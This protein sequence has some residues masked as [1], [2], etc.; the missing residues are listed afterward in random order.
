[1]AFVNAADVYFGSYAKFTTLGK[2]EGAAKAGPDN[3]I[4][5]IGTIEFQLDD[6][7]RSIAWMKNRFGHMVGQLDPAMSYTLAVMNAKGW[8]L[9][10]VLSFVAFTEHPDS[11]KNSYWGEVA[12][13]AFAPRYGEEFGEFMRTFSLQVADGSRPNPALTNIEVEGILRDPISWKPVMTIDMPRMDANTVII[14]NRRSMHDKL[15][16]QGRGKN[17]GCYAISWLFIFAVLGGGF[18]VLRSMG[19]I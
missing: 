13:I 16:D 3:A 18:W 7:K 17:P 8:N 10:Y 5:D 6:Q 11:D 1:M 2:N 19:I 15:L 14:K 4:G 12:V 9:H